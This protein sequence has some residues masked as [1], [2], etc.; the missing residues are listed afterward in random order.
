MPDAV[1]NDMSRNQSFWQH[2]FGAYSANN[3][4]PSGGHTADVVIVGGGY[5]GLTAAR[6]L[7]LDDPALKVIVLEKHEIGFGASGRNGG[8]NMTL[9][10]VEPEITVMRWGKD[11]ARA[12]QAYMKEAVAYVRGVIEEYD[13]DSDY[14]HTGM[15]RVAY[16]EKQVARLRKT[17]SLLNE[18][19]QPG[20]YEFFEHS[21]IQERLNSPRMKAAIVEP[22]TGILDPC[23][24]VRALKELA[25]KLGVE[26]YENTEVIDI[27]RTASGVELKTSHA[28][29][30]AAKLLIAT[31]AWS[32]QTPNGELA[33][34]QRPA[35]TYQIVSEPLTE[36]EWKALKWLG[37]MSIEDNRQLVHYMRITRCGRITLGGGNVGL[38]YKAQMDRWHDESIWQALE[39]HFRWLFP[40]LREKK[41]Y[42]KWGGAVS[43]NMD[44]TPEIGYLNNK[45]IVYSSGCIG[46]GV[47]LTQ[48]NGR[49]IADLLQDLQTER[50]QFWI[51]NRKTIS[52][53]PGDLLA[54][55][56]VK[57]IE[58][59]LKAVDWYEERSLRQSS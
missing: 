5:T 4:I 14:E 56:G 55:I 31:N 33:R 30:S 38:Q 52:L 26:I 50:S 46:H 44:M 3:S 1:L 58:K 9:F 18:L 49:V 25:E 23:K 16:S 43:A 39:A 45:N 40:T 35:W 10:G 11:K 59:A 27:Q 20:D 37:R 34:S 21:A 47:S 15:W 57:T 19:G 28:Q 29:I 54:F 53:P 32:H 12:A 24:H 42:Y 48:L 13:L 2:K 36:Q 22:Q 6:E 51:V 7:K 8:F 41:I 17:Y